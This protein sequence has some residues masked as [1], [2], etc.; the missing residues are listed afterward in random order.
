MRIPGDPTKSRRHPILIRQGFTRV[1]LVSVMGGGVLLA[2]LLSPNVLGARPQAQRI[3][4]GNNLRQVGIALGQFVGDNGEYP[5]GINKDF[6]K[7]MYPAHSTSWRGAL[8]T[9]ITKVAPTSNWNPN[10]GVWDCP[11]ASKPTNHPANI[12]YSDFGYNWTGLGVAP[13]HNALGL[14]GHFSGLGSDVPYAPP[15]R[16][17]EVAL[18]AEMVALGDG[19]TGWNGVVQDG[20]VA[21]SRS[22]IAQEQGGSTERSNRRHE[23]TANVYFCDGHV[24]S[25]TLRRLFVETSDRA[26]RRWNRDNLPHAERLEP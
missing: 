20:L 12:A 1:E 10:G 19:L 9:M 25:P 24:E 5:L 8:E 21:L 23:G 2:S 3:Q 15:V 13:D 26:L 17:S 14:G 16:Q 7:G 11:N 18:P 6:S 4:C 22:P